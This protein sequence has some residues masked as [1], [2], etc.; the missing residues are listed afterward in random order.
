VSIQ[1]SPIVNDPPA[2]SAIAVP[3]VSPISVA[4]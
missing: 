1:A 3:P 4:D 2:A